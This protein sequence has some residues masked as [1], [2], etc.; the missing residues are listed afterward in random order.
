MYNFNF[1]LNFLG[2]VTF[3]LQMDKK[4]SQKVNNNEKIKIENTQICKYCAKFSEWRQVN[5]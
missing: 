2:T 3:M 5:C 1:N 4:N